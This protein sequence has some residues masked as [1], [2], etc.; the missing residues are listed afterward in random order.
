MSEHDAHADPA[1]DQ[2]ATPDDTR[3]DQASGDPG[4]GHAAEAL[5]VEPDADEVE[6]IEAEREER[7]DP[8]NRPDG[9]EVDNT[10]REFDAE[11]GMFTDAEDY[12]TAEERFPPAEEQGT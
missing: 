5:A 3:D 2:D 8:D 4:A 10:Q 12:D 9:A 11:K 7:L 6:E 1:P